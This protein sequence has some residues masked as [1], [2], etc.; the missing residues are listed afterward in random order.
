MDHESKSKPS[1]NATKVND[2]AHHESSMC[3]F[4]H[5]YALTIH[6]LSPPVVFKQISHPMI[7]KQS[8]S[9]RHKSGWWDPPCIPQ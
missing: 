8:Q 9:Q 5:N 6:N 2:K 3:S 4:F 7:E 1:H